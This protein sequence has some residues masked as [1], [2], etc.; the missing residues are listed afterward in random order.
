[1]KK[2]EGIIALDGKKKKENGHRWKGRE[3]NRTELWATRP[4]AHCMKFD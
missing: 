2:I 4:L 1:M 3:I